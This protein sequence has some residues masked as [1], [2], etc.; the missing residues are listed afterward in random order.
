M[1][2]LVAGLALLLNCAGADAAMRLHGAVA[3]PGSCPLG[4]ALPDGCPGAPVGGNFQHSNF[5]TSYAL[6]SGQTYATRPTWN[7]AGVD[8]AIG[9][10]SA[11][12]LKIPG[13]DAPPTGCSYSSVTHT[14][15]CNVASTDVTFDG[16]DFGANNCTFLNF[17]NPFSGNITLENSNFKWGTN[18]GNIAQLVNIGNLTA[19]PPTVTVLNSVF[20]GVGT[21]WTYEATSTTVATTLLGGLIGNSD[22]N[23]TYS[24]FLHC[25][26]RCITS[27]GY[28]NF[29]M[30]YDYEEGMTYPIGQAIGSISGTTLCITSF[31]AGSQTGT[32]KAG[33]PVMGNGNAFLGQITSSTG[34]CA[35]TAFQLS[36]PVVTASTQMTLLTSNH[37]DAEQFVGTGGHT[38]ALY[39]K[40]YSLCMEG[41]DTTGTTSCVIPNNLNGTTNALTSWV[42][43][44]NVFVANKLADAW[45]GVSNHTGVSYLIGDM[46]PMASVGS[47]NWTNNYIDPTGAVG[48]MLVTAG[49]PTPTYGG[50]INLTDN[51][52]IAD[53]NIINCNNHG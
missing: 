9:I 22:V 7:V 26:G 32:V 5:F 20:D 43:D 27:A 2:L 19:A 16:W 14:M 28:G 12:V 17:A 30:Q 45:S 44:H 18:C 34:S 35:G 51:S 52:P 11:T 41:S 48:C 10:P 53:D 8:Y 29:V 31:V 42:T 47:V 37:G 21:P 50:N 23:I 1:K 38:F 46:N 4:A 40:S 25:P 33:S 49:M 24:V 3:A 39:Q 15:T 36:S 6:Q 13:T